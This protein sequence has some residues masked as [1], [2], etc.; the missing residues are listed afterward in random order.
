MPDPVPDRDMLAEALAYAAQAWPVFPCSPETKRP[1]VSGPRGGGGFKRAS[2]NQAQIGR[3]WKQWP[4]AMIGIPTGE[5]IGGLFVIDLDAG[6]DEQTG[7]IFEAP[8]LLEALERELGESLPATATVET[9]RGGWHLFFTMSEPIGN[10]AA[11]IPRVDVRGTGGYVIAPPSVRADGKAYRWLARRAVYESPPAALVDLILRRGRWSPANTSKAAS[12]PSKTTDDGVMHKYALAALDSEARELAGAGPGTR[13]D[14]INRA[15]FALGQLAGA[16]MLSPAVIRATLQDI[17]RTWPSFR[18]SCGTI[19]S[20]LAAG[21]MLPRDLREVGHQARQRHDARAPAALRVIEGGP[22]RSAPRPKAPDDQLEI[23]DVMRAARRRLDPPPAESRNGAPPGRWSEDELGLPKEDPCPVI[24]LGIDGPRYHFLDSA[25]QYRAITA[26]SFNH[27]GIQDLFA[28]APNW[29]EWAFP[30]YGKARSVKGADGKSTTIF[31]IESFK[32][33]A[34][35]K[36]LF[37]A[38]ERKNLFSPEN[39]M[40]GRGA[41]KFRDGA[42][43]YHAGEEIWIVEGGRLRAIEP[44][45]VYDGPDELVFPRT[46]ALPPPWPKPIPAA[47]NPARELL[48]GF[49]LWKWERPEVDPLLLLGWV[50]VA[51]LG[52]ALD[53]RSAVFLIGDKNTGKSTLQGVL[54]DIFGDALLDSANTTAAGIYQSLD[55]DSRP[56]AVDEIEATA[57]N[58]KVMAVVELARQASSGAFGRRGGAD[59]RAG[60]H[61]FQMRSAFLFSSINTPPLA[62]QDLSRIAVL[63]L[64]ELDA[65]AAAAGAPPPIDIDTCGRKVLT[66][67]MLEWHRWRTT[68]SAYREV[69]AAGG[70]NGRGQDTYGTLLAAADLIVGSE[71]AEELGLA[72]VDDLSAWSQ[73]LHV[74]TLPEVGDAL[75]NWRACINHLLQS[76][77]D[78]WRTGRRHTVGQFIED[79]EDPD[80]EMAPADAR[81][82]LSDAGLGLLYDQE[83]GWLL[84]VPNSSP[85]VERLFFGSRWQ[86]VPGI[87][88]WT[89]AMRQAPT[90]VVVKRNTA[91]NRVRINSVQQRCT[92]VALRV[93]NEPEPF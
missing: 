89:E 39:K 26:S 1:L 88:G 12:G 19:E 68:Y 50:G 23:R 3:W 66:R 30:R 70:H 67:L 75:P 41:W 55:H 34:V 79:L 20:G 71:L 15:A 9:P 76:R 33:D 90:N 21:M 77:V 57:D 45:L 54:K 65:A 63:R 29:P 16:G 62:P 18:K 35:R 37:R 93:F 91:A 52:G 47:D 78:T 38:C 72:M 7:E 92:L 27:A 53:W 6:V 40:R 46:P 60:A 58:R 85:L 86:G 48:A 42:I 61:E 31:P 22:R 69:L 10:R 73:L 81:R 82:M 5:P 11:I 80:Q 28:A 4:I 59:A 49:R 83:L 32:D 51:F 8:G 14:A 24:P 25:R 17:V 64:R 56:V 84:A 2:I 36:T 87:G 13:S 74:E 43:Y 44:G